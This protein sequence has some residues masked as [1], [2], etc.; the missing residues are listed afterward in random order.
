MINIVL[1]HFKRVCGNYTQEL[2]E[3]ERERERGEREREI[4]MKYT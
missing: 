4:Q 2:R 1:I 3:R